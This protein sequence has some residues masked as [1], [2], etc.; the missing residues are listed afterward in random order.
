[1]SIA[2]QH[3]DLLAAD[4]VVVADPHDGLFAERRAA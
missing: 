4:Q 3:P 1:M 2:A